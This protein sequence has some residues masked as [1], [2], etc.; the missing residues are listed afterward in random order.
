LCALNRLYEQESVF[1]GIIL[2]ANGLLSPT[3]ALV[4]DLLY[5]VSVAHPNYPDSKRLFD[6]HS[7]IGLPLEQPFVAEVPLLHR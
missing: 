7:L 4:V 3:L 5:G 2:A 1:L 6:V